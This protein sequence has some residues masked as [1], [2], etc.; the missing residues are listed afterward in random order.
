M[1]RIG[2][3]GYSGLVGLCGGH[4]VPLGLWIVGTHP[5]F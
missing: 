2:P 3:A 1:L 5:A 4:A